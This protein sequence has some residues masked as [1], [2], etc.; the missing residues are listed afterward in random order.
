M[1]RGGSKLC[2]V[3]LPPGRHSTFMLEQPTLA[4]EPAAIAGEA[5]VGADDPVA[6]YD[7]RDRIAAVRKPDGAARLRHPE[8]GSECAVGHRLSSRNGAQR[9][10]YGLLE[11]G[12]AGPHGNPRKSLDLPGEILCERLPHPVRGRLVGELV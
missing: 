4:F 2:Q 9:R 7:D 1:W 10:P 3:N 6:G 12:A 8:P 11:R 5:A